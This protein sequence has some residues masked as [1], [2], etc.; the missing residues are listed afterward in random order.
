MLQDILNWAT[1]NGQ[2]MTKAH[3]W[4]HDHNWLLA[5]TIFQ[6]IITICYSW[7]A[8]IHCMA[9]KVWRERNKE[10][11]EKKSLLESRHFAHLIMALIFAL[12]GLCGYLFQILTIWY[13]LHRIEVIMHGFLAVAS[14]IWPV[15]VMGYLTPN[16]IPIYTK[17]LK[18]TDAPAW[19]AVSVNEA[20]AEVVIHR[21]ERSLNQD[22]DVSLSK[23]D[24]EF[25]I[26]LL[27]TREII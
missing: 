27:K 25:I 6:V 3:C 14:L 13:P 5:M 18:D 8:Y 10:E 19:F 16:R 23:S 12:C 1:N 21:L 20:R 17:L 24:K 26:S 15:W 22:E 7:I 4:A 9:F 2:Y 11:K